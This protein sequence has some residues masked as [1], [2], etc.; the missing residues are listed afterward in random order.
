MNETI[1]ELIQN[2]RHEEILLL[3]SP[4]YDRFKIRAAIFLER[5]R[6][7][8]LYIKGNTFE[9]AYCFYKLKNFKRALKVLN[10]LEGTNVEILKGQCLYFMGYFKEAFHKLEKHGKSDEFAVCLSACEAMNSLATNETSNLFM[11]K[12]D[13]KINKSVEYTFT[14]P[15][16]K[17]EVDFNRCYKYIQDENKY[18][19]E[20]ERDGIKYENITG[21]YFKK[22]IACLRNEEIDSLTK[23]QREIFDFNKIEG[24]ELSKVILFQ[25]NFSGDVKTEFKEMQKKYLT[26]KDCFSKRLVLKFIFNN[27]NRNKIDSKLVDWGIKRLEGLKNEECSDE[28]AMLKVLQL[29]ESDEAYKKEVEMFLNKFMK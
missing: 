23:N 25:H 29:K 22:Q 14:D 19:S 16:C 6:D 27:L 17:L 4:Q 26:K 21:N 15:E 3:D 12:S 1:K 7:A 18:I 13:K 24:F 5:Y 10:K 11:I 9:K 2:D 20:L 28:I 8:M